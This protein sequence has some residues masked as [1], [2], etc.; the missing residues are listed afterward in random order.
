MTDVKHE[1]V[2]ESKR[3]GLIWRGSLWWVHKQYVT[4][5]LDGGGEKLVKYTCL[6]GDK[7]YPPYE[8]GDRVRHYYGARYLLKI[9]SAPE[10]EK[11]C[12]LC[13]TQNN[14]DARECGVCGKSLIENK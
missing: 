3:K 11:I 10:T 13:G 5:K 8:V 4:V 9:A 14:P 7:T 1:D 2:V 12:V 6:D